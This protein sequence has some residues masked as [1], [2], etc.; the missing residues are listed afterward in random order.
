M[1]ASVESLITKYSQINTVKNEV[2]LNKFCAFIW[3]TAINVFVF[4]PMSIAV[5]EVNQSDFR[6]FVNNFKQWNIYDN[7]IRFSNVVGAIS[8]SET[9]GVLYDL[10]IY[11][12]NYLKLTRNI[13]KYDVAKN[14]LNAN[15]DIENFSSPSEIAQIFIDGNNIKVGY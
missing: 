4:K 2:D 15:G 5:D 10:V 14:V 9:S 11:L 8:I 1:I 13:Y 3:T 7:S 12:L 6:L